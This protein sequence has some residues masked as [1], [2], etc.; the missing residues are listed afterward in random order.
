MCDT[1]SFSTK[2]CGE[3]FKIQS[4]QSGVLNC[5]SQKVIYILKCRIC[6]EAFYVGKV[7]TKF[8]ARFNNYKSAY[9]SYRKKRKV[10]QQRFHE[11]Y[12]Q[13]SHNGIDDWQFTLI[14]QCETYKQLKEKETFW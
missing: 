11:H 1:D 2:S 12:G 8:R 7:K 3:K 4:V 10:S 14:E 9:R 5:N 6:G 13:H